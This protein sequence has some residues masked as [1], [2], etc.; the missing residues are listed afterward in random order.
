QRVVR[1]CRYDGYASDATGFVKN[2]ISLIK[3]QN[4]V[5]G[6]SS[7]NTLNSQEERV[8]MEHTSQATISGWGSTDARDLNNAQWRLQWA[9]MPLV[10]NAV[11]S[12]NKQYAEKITDGMICAG[13]V[14]TAAANHESA[15]PCVGDSGGPLVVSAGSAEFLEGITSTGGGC[16]ASPYAVFTRV[17]HYRAWI[18]ETRRTEKNCVAN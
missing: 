2:D 14:Q 8:L 16:A 3:L 18:D 17:S 15:S 1:I 4:P 12:A 5:A 13:S 11:C 10:T 6:V 9:V 7:I